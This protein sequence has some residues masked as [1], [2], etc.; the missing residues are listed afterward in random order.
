MTAYVE[1]CQRASVQTL[2]L[3]RSTETYFRKVL[4]STHMPLVCCN[5]LSIENLLYK[6]GSC[7]LVP[8]Q[9]ITLHITSFLSSDANSQLQKLTNV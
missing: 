1:S 7:I 5:N 9:H 8:N 4:T 3:S 6:E 2:F